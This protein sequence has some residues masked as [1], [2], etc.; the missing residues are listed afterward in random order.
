MDTA[1]KAADAA[2]SD[3]ID[4]LS[5]NTSGTTDALDARLDT[6]EGKIT[7]LEGTVN[8]ATTGLAATK[9]IADAAKAKADTALQPADITTLTNK[10]NA[11]EDK[12]TIV[13]P[14]DGV[15]S[16]YTNDVPNIATANIKTNADYLIADDEGK[17]FYW[18]YINNNWELISGAGG[19]GTGSSSGEFAATLESITSPDENTDYFVGNDTIGYIHYRYI[20][21]ENNA[22]G[23]FVKILPN[24]LINDLSVDSYGGLVAHS[25]GDDQ[26]N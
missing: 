20:P 8:N 1:Y 11:L 5:S 2:L 23:R 24:N 10:V 13:V 7:T 19:G 15:H 26:T 12:D 9:A 21:G 14:Y 17:Y 3:R 18:R 4:T 22:A 6:A 16:N 25:I